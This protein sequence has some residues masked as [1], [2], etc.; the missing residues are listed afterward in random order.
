MGYESLSDAEKTVFCIDS[1]LREMENGGFVQFFHHEVGAQAEDTLAALERVKSR[2]IHAI[3]DEL[4]DLFPDR[5][6]PADED[7]RSALV[8][9]LE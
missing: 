4:L 2:D 3:F 9:Q 6:V 8:S 5:A 7:A 1:L